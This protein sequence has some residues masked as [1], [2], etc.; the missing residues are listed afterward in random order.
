MGCVVTVVTGIAPAGKRVGGTG[1]T[2]EVE[3]ENWEQLSDQEGSL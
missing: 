3:S 2:G 1:S